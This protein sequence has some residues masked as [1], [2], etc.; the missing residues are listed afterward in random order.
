MKDTIVCF[1]L[2]CKENK[3]LNNGED[4]ASLYN[5]MLLCPEISF[6]VVEIRGIYSHHA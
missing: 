1:S 6:F 5:I 3:N 4:N 2:E